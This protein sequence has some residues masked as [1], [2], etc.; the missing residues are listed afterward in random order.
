MMGIPVCGNVDLVAFF[1]KLLA[2]SA[3]I[4]EVFVEKE[5]CVSMILFQLF[6]SLSISRMT[7]RFESFSFNKDRSILD[8]QNHFAHCLVAR[9]KYLILSSRLDFFYFIFTVYCSVNTS[10]AETAEERLIQN[11]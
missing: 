2:A 9:K 8:A 1:N 3:A 11:L 6:W 10:L 4:L 5:F 7:L